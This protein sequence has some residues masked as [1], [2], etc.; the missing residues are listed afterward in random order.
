MNFYVLFSV[1]FLSNLALSADTALHFCLEKMTNM[2]LEMYSF[3]NIILCFAS[4]VHTKMGNINHC[5]QSAAHK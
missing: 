3:E 5:K 2:I 4:T 1:C